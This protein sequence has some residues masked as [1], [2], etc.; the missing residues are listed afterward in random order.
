MALHVFLMEMLLVFLME[1]L[2]S[3]YFAEFDSAVPLS[4]LLLMEIL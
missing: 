2:L 4:P 3:N 1:M